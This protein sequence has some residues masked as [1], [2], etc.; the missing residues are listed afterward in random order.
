MLNVSIKMKRASS[1]KGLL[2]NTADVLLQN[3]N[4]VT[5]DIIIIN[6]ITSL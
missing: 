5:T 2:V 4:N 1:M 3:A 6:L